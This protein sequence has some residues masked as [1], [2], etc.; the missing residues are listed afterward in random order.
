MLLFGGLLTGN[1]HYWACLNGTCEA[2]N[3]FLNNLYLLK[4][5]YVKNK[6]LQD[7]LPRTHI[8]NGALLWLSYVVFRLLLFPYWICTWRIDVTDDK[9]LTWD[10]VSLYER[11]FYPSVTVFLLVISFTWFVK[12]TQGL[13]KAVTL[14][15]VPADNGGY[16]HLEENGQAKSNGALKKKEQLQPALEVDLRGARSS[17]LRASIQ[18]RGGSD[19]GG[20]NGQWQRQW[21]WRRHAFSNRSS[22]IPATASRISTATL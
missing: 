15:L 18:G 2:T 14:F 3:I 12:I 7:Y 20:G 19:S 8:I 17:S 5:I 16:L 21:L 10:R 1:M 6:Q 4:A 13:F 22:R 9:A 11:Y